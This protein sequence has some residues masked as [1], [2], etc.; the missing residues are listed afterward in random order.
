MKK[1]I[2]KVTA[3]A[4][5]FGWLGLVLSYFGM[6]G[7]LRL[8]NTSENWGELGFLATSILIVLLLSGG[9][10]AALLVVFVPLESGKHNAKS[11]R[12]VGKEALVGGCTWG[13]IVPIMSLLFT[14]LLMGGNV[15]GMVNEING[16]L[17][18]KGMTWLISSA[19][20]GAITFGWAAH[21]GQQPEARHGSSS[22][23]SSPSGGRVRRER[24]IFRMS[25]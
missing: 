9:F 10:A 15:L 3:V 18:A 20:S 23:I 17:T 5:L 11:V 13:V 22:P 24:R 16:F 12:R 8:W 21:A 4:G 1:S 19:I 6:N 14:Q 25:V 7:I 2:L